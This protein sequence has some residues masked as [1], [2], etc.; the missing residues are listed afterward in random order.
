MPLQDE[1]AKLP[2]LT[3]SQVHR[4]RGTLMPSSPSHDSLE[5]EPPPII[6][7]QQTG[8]DFNTSA[9]LPLVNRCSN[10]VTALFGSCTAGADPVVHESL[11]NAVSRPGTSTISAPPI[12]PSGRYVF[13]KEIGRGGV[14]IVFDG[15]DTLLDRSVALKVLL[16]VHRDKSTVRRRFLEEA[17]ITARLQHP[18]IVAIHGLGETKDGLPYFAMR[19]VLGETLEQILQSER[20]PDE[21]ARLLIAFLQLSQAVAYAHHVGV[22]H[23]DL[24]PANIM[25][26]SFGDV[27]VMD[28]GLGKVLGEKEPSWPEDDEY[29]SEEASTRQGTVFGTP[30][31]L[32]P[33][34]ARGEIDLIDERADVFGLGSIL[35][36]ILTGAPPHIGSDNR[37]VYAKA[38][39]AD[40]AE[41]VSRLNA[42]NAP[43]DLIELA[44]WCLNASPSGRPPNAGDMVEVLSF[45]LRSDLRRAELD[46]VRFFEVSLDLFCIAGTDGYFRR[47]NENFPRVLGHSTAD[48]ISRPFIDFVHPDDRENTKQALVALSEGS[49]VIRFVNRY[50]HVEGHFLWLEWNAHSAPEERLVYAVARDVTERVAHAELIHRSH[51]ALLFYAAGNDSNKEAIIGTNLDGTVQVWSTGAE[52]LFGYRADEIVGRCVTALFPN[53]GA[54]QSTE[55]LSRLKNCSGVSTHESVRLRKDGTTVAVTCTLYPVK[56]ERGTIIGVSKVMRRNGI[57]PVLGEPAAALG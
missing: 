3:A 57:P 49:Q 20:T 52:G 41:T 55:L 2:R 47:I 51:L 17:R 33:E 44:I 38:V 30:A 34:Q 14:G 21:I 40:M 6:D 53:N 37:A 42:C 7:T 12:D 11:H 27:M 15:H 9:P 1:V 54:E 25:V 8:F 10:E 43:L 46:L 45:H 24:K 28:W 16:P 5:S 23:R 35:C 39:A 31:Y 29:D 50:Q 48:L 22:I 56:D 26:G 18:G 4:Q 36:E 19:L 13:R 32:P